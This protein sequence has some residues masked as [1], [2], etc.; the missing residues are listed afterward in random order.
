MKS[1][2]Q[3]GVICTAPHLPGQCLSSPVPGRGKA[4][5]PAQATA[6]SVET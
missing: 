5:T 3:D 1:S 6:A 2:D 4:S